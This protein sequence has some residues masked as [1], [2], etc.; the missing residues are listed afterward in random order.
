MTHLRHILAIVAPVVLVAAS[1]L[2]VSPVAQ[3][4][5]TQHPAI[6]AYVLLVAGVLRAVYKALTGANTAGET[7]P[8]SPPGPG[9]QTM[10]AK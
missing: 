7:D 2:A 3:N 5:A 1:S 9:S 8:P 4:L 6:V 10:S